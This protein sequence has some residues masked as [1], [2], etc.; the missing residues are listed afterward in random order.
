M[1]RFFAVMHEAHWHAL[2]RNL[3]HVKHTAALKDLRRFGR[4]GKLF[5]GEQHSFFAPNASNLSWIV[6]AKKIPP[7]RD[8]AAGLRLRVSR[9][10]IG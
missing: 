6:M 2:A 7:K 8:C 4:I 10:A 3:V 5:H 1:R 9:E